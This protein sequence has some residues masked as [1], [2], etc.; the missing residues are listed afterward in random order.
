MKTKIKAT[1]SFATGCLEVLEVNASD[2]GVKKAVIKIISEGL[3]KD[4]QR[5]YTKE[6]LSTGASMFTDAKMYLNHISAYERAD[7]PERSVNDYVATIKNAQFVEGSPSYITGEAMIHG[8]P[9]YSVDDVYSWLKNIKEAGGQ[10][11]LSIHAYLFGEQGEFDARP[12]LMISGI[13]SVAS[14]DF[15]T[16]ANA[17][18]KV[19]TV[20]STSQSP[21]KGGNEMDIKTLTL[22]ELKSARP[23]LCEAIS[24]ES[25]KAADTAV[26]EKEALKK[27]LS[28]MKVAQKKESCLK[29]A[30]AVLKDAKLPEATESRV[31]E[32]IS[33]IAITETTESI[34]ADVE[35]IVK[36]EKDYLESLSKTKVFGNE[37]TESAD[38]KDDKSVAEL[39]ESITSK[40]KAKK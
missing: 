30:D 12:V 5:F 27:E 25:K 15:V 17:G 18:G 31:R 16:T 20:E 36:V 29:E 6:A 21:E 35:A 22:D 14:V 40:Q 23:D 37:H 11:D 38:K 34:K 7:R 28:D 1:E 13:E 19:E 10:A 9:T 26:A 2:T 4:R 33:A 8:S 39:L 3:T 24:A 32:K